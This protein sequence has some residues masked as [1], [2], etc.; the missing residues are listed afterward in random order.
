MLQKPA[1]GS[2]CEYNQ[3]ALFNVSTGYKNN[4]AAIANPN[5]TRKV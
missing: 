2:N 1:T 4:D 5:I 3:S